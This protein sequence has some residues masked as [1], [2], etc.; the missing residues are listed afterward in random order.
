MLDLM[1]RIV[2]WLICAHVAA[3]PDIRLPDRQVARAGARMARTRSR[4][5]HVYIYIYIYMCIYVYSIYG[6]YICI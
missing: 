6:V 4:T 5:S 1:C 2:V 3:H